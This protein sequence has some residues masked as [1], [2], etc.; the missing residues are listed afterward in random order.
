L[1]ACFDLCLC[2]I[3][4]V[5]HGSIHF[6]DRVSLP[7]LSLPLH[8]RLNLPGPRCYINISAYLI[9]SCVFLVWCYYVFYVSLN[10]NHSAMLRVNINAAGSD[11]RG[12]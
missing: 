5:Y 2:W 8:P 3:E 6:R 7:P 12:S 10:K 1:P 11:A 4:H 9:A